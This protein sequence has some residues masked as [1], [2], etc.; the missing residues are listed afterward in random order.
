MLDE[1]SPDQVTSV[2]RSLI[3]AVRALNGGGFQPIF[4]IS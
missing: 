1:L 4:D 3:V 2:R